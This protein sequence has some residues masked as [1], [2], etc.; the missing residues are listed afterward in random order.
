MRP[1]ERRQ[2]ILELLRQ[3]E[4]ISVEE[5]ARITATS[6]ETIRRD[7]SDLAESGLV[8]KFHGGAALPLPASTKTPSRP[9]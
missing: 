8:T 1:N 5:L 9:A 4:R 6:Q 7:L 2:H 3:R